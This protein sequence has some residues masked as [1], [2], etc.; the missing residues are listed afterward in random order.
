[1]LA[2]FFKQHLYVQ[3]A[4]DRLVV[5]DPSTKNQFAELP[6]VAI[7]NSGQA[8][9]T[10]VAFGSEA[11]V[12]AST[13]NTSVHNPLAHPRSLVSDF[14]VAERLLKAAFRRVRGPSLFQPAP[15][16]VMHPLGCAAPRIRST[17]I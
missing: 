9:A 14:T 7:E 8:K 3:L 15:V 5:R 4:P 13:P 12:H 2:R 1:M 11:R 17:S 16:V 6:E 10:I